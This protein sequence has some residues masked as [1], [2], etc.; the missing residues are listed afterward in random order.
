MRRKWAAVVALAGLASVGTALY[1]NFYR[2]LDRFNAESLLFVLL[3]LGPYLLC[4][5]GC[6]LSYSDIV[7]AF[8]GVVRWTP[9]FGPLAA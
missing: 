9:I 7:R 3:L 2:Q 4:A 6:W 8:A 1:F 5:T